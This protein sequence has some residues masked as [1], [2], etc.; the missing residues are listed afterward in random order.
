VTRIRILADDLTGALDT[1]AAF[2]GEV[3]VWLDRPGGVGSDGDSDTDNTDDDAPVAVVATATRDVPVERLDALLEPCV[4]WLRDADV[5]MKKVDSLLRGNTFAECA[6]LGLDYARIVFAP[7]YPKQGRFM[8]DGRAFVAQPGSGD[9]RPIVD[10]AICD[11]LTASGIEGRRLATEPWVPDVHDDASLDAVA[12]ASLEATSRGWLWCGSAGLAHALARV[13]GLALPA[14]CLADT[15]S[16][17]AASAG[18]VLLVSATRNPVL[19]RQWAALMSTLPH[20]GATL[21]PRS[22]D[23]GAVTARHLAPRDEL[24]ADVAAAHLA[25]RVRELL[26]TTPRPELLA[27][28]GGDTL[29][30]LCRAVG[31]QRL[32]AGASP[33]EGWGRATIVGGRWNGVTCLSR[34]GAFGGS[35]DLVELL[36]PWL[37]DRRAA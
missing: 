36:G 7:A 28:V 37:G 33:R 31:A 18:R 16:R 2:A 9:V 19:Q 29:L 15:S 30:A 5:S 14:A 8:V 1:A 25:Q 26:D 34:S 27:V 17:A 35:G 11:A 3:P 6:R 22:F 23:V 4:A 21:D 24:P 20:T 12:A 10:G 32:A 13:H